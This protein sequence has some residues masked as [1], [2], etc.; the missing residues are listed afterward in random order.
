MCAEH[1]YAKLDTGV[2]TLA[3]RTGLNTEAARPRRLKLLGGGGRLWWSVVTELHSAHAYDF[4]WSRVEHP[5]TQKTGLFFTYK[6]LISRPL[7]PDKTFTPNIH[8]F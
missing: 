5:K 1:I 4:T 3:H 8:E 7:T 6:I 2:N